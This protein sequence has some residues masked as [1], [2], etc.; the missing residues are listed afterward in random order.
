MV[1][2]IGFEMVYSRAVY[3]PGGGWYRVIVLICKTS[4]CSSRLPEKIPIS[5][6]KRTLCNVQSIVFHRGTVAVISEHR[7]TC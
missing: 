2:S 5:S 1:F 3:S 4:C 7:D 6:M